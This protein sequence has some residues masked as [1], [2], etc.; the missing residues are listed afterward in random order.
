MRTFFSILALATLMGCSE[1]TLPVNVLGPGPS[2]PAG[3]VGDPPGPTQDNLLGST[4]ASGAGGAT[5]LGGSISMGS[6]ASPGVGGSTGQGGA[7][8][9]GGTAPAGSPFSCDIDTAEEHLCYQFGS[10]TAAQLSS[11]TSTCTSSEMGTV[12]TACSTAGLLGTCTLPVTSGFTEEE[13]WYTGTAITAA[14]A[15]SSC[16]SAMGTWAAD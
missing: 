10:L 13:F 14:T 4:S 11:A 9:T 1:G 12:G 15:Q 8:G 16:T 3:P 6:G 5:G 7:D 2:D